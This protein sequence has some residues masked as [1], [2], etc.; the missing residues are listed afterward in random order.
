MADGLR[1]E[2]HGTVTDSCCIGKSW[3]SAESLLDAEF[4]NRSSRE[5]E[6]ERQAQLSRQ[7][8]RACGSHSAWLNW[9]D[10]SDL[11]RVVDGVRNRVDRIRCL[12]NAVVPQQFYPFFAA[13]AEI[14]RSKDA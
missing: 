5:R 10:E 4:T 8:A 14:E 3:S 7:S 9:P 2:V 13:I 1:T 11:D 6:R 12:G